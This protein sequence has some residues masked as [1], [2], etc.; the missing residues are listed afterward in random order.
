MLAVPSAWQIQVL[1]FRIF[2]FLKIFVSCLV[3]SVDSEPLHREGHAKG[4]FAK[5]TVFPLS[6]SIL[7]MTREMKLSS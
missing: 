6:M 7:L 3:E 5:G 2:F 4:P 1:L